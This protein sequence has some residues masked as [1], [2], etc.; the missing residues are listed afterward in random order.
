[1]STLNDGIIRLYDTVF[2][3]APDADGF[4]FWTDAADHGTSLNA[5]AGQFITAPEFAATYGQPDSASFVQSM[6]GNVLGR[7]GEAEGVSFWVYGLDHGLTSRADVV[8]AF[9]ESAEHIANL[10]APAPVPVVEPAPVTPTSTNPTP[11]QRDGAFVFDGE[12]WVSRGTSGPDAMAAH[13]GRNII[14]GGAGDDTVTGG[15]D[16]DVII[17]G[18]GNDRL[19]G[20]GGRDYFLFHPGDGHDTVADLQR[21]D[22]LQFDGLTAGDVHIIAA[23]GPPTNPG[24]FSSFAGYD[25][26]YGTDTSQGT[27]RLDGITNADLDW[28]QDSFVYR[29]DLV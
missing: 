28:V 13:A 21:G 12:D 26:V 27:F 10:A 4:R 29:P 6:Y 15:P 1:M 8:V 18:P 17:G 16:D 23:H 5:I 11:G 24:E 25:V 19:T 2:D 20:G 22:H 9:S 3:R 7:G 14:D